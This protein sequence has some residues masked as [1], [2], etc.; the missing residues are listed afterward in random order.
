MSEIVLLGPQHQQ[1]NVSSALAK[2]DQ[3]GPV[4]VVTC[5]WQEAEMEEAEELSSHLRRPFIH[6]KLHQR[7][8]DVFHKDPEFFAAYRQRQNELR[9]LQELYRIRLAHALA[10]AWELMRRDGAEELVAPEREAAIEAVR[11]LDQHHLRRMGEVHARFDA[12]WRPE[13]REVVAG[14]RREIAEQLEEASAVVVAGGHV[15]VLLYRL[16]LFNVAPLMEKKPVVAWSA[17][18]MVLA[19][20]IVLFHDSP[21]QGEGN[22]EVLDNGLGLVRGVIP[23]PNARSRLRLED[24]VRV[25]LLARRFAPRACAALDDGAEL[26][27]HD[28]QWTARPSTLRL[29]ASGGMVEFTS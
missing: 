24:P 15:A 29:A 14:H 25:S 9:Q 7:G 27:C 19:E 28:H 6:L 4:A 18:A 8:D 20:L 12:E 1:P 2:W 11:A 22:P 26:Y 21:P 16:L 5:G 10:A 17:G 3:P 13:E 23:F